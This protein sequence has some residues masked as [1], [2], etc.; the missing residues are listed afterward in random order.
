[1]SQGIDECPRIL[2]QLH[3]VKLIK[4]WQNQNENIALLTDMNENSSRMG[5]LQYAV[6]YEYQLIDTIRELHHNGISKLPP[7]SLTGSVPIDGIFVSSQLRHIAKG[8]WISI[9]E[10]IGDHRALF[11]DI[12]LQTL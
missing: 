6:K 2:F 7:T 1:M 8:C 10:S 11:I 12:P 4:Q 9:N 3:L 5:P